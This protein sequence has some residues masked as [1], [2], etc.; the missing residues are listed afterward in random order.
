VAG[1]RKKACR[2]FFCPLLI[3]LKKS[4]LLLFCKTRLTQR[5]LRRLAFCL[6]LHYSIRKQ[7]LIVIMKVTATM[8]QYSANPE[9]Y[10]IMPCRRSGKSGLILP[11][12]SLGLWHNFGSVDSFDN[13]REMIR[14]AF[15][16]GIFHFDLA[17]NYGPAPGSAEENFGNIFND[18]LKKHRDELIISTKAGYRMWEGPYGE[19]GSRK[20]LIS[21]CDQSLKRMKLDYVDIFYHH[22]PDPETPIEE[23]MQALDYIVRSGRALY[24]GLSNYSR[25]DAAKAIAILRELKT[26]CVLYQGRYNIFDRRHEDGGV[27][28]LLDKKGVGA[29][30]FSPLA[31][32]VLST[33]YLNGVPENS[34]AARNHFLKKQSITPG[35]QAKVEQLN[36]IALARSQTLPQMA[37]A[38]L[39]NRKA[40][41]SVLCGASSAQQIIECA[42]A[43]ENIIF[44]KDEIKAIDSI[45]RKQQEAALKLAKLR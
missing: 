5:L 39:L 9:R 28:D 45:A 4:S 32:G 37:L 14:C 31:Q 15:D 16:L 1:E 7:I 21:S 38:W 27:F 10:D 18:D 20:T 44:T 2:H 30:C 42:K 6:L 33:K 24:V 8:N 40:V 36:Q 22:R 25:K 3:Y 17:N 35:L 13:A 11:Q 29:I 23:S 19:W 41:A 26:P 34:R 43:P 12:V